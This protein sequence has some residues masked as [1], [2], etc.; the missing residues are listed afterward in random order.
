MSIT[1]DDYYRQGRYAISAEHE[2]KGGFL[3]S[4]TP[5]EELAG[6]LM[7][8]FHC[9]KEAGWDRGAAEAGAWA[10]VLAPANVFFRH[11][12][13]AV[14]NRWSHQQKQRKP[15]GFPP[16]LIRAPRRFPDAFPLEV[17]RDILGLE[18]TE[19]LLNDGEH[20]RRWWEPLRRGMTPAKA[21]R[22][23]LVDFHAE[24]CTI[25]FRFG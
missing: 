25:R 6:F 7:E 12:L 19:N 15:R 17:E 14:L 5:R 4:K 13:A 2:A 9:W 24:G 10:C 1:Q 8:R 3:R 21:P 23:A 20:D 22:E 11:T 18:A 16:L